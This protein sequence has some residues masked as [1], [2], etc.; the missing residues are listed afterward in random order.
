MR[1]LLLLAKVL[2]KKDLND[3]IDDGGNQHGVRGG[4]GDDDGDRDGEGECEGEGE[5][6]VGAGAAF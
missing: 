4:S 1:L 3:S 2:T 5:G 6:G